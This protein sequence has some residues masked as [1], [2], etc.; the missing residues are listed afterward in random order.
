MDEPTTQLSA[1]ESF[2][3]WRVE[4][5]LAHG[6]MG[7]LYLARHP[8]LPRT[9]VIKVLSPQLSAD[10]RFRD[11]FLAE[12]TRMSTL[13]H[14]HVM[15]IYDSGT[16][17]DGT[18]YLVM[19][20]VAGGD[21]RQL[22]RSTGPL[23]PRRASRLLSQI[24]AALDAAHR[25]GVVHRDVKPE[26][27]LLSSVEP[28]DNDHALLTDFGISREE[29]SPT[30]LTATGELLLTPA[31]AAPEQAL[32]KTVDSRADQYALACILVELLT[33]RPPY[34]NDAPVVMLMA[35]LQEP[36]PALA[37]ELGLPAQ[38]DDV[39][40]RAMAKNPDE[41]YG[42]CRDFAHAVRAVLDPAGA[43]A[44]GD[45]AKPTVPSAPAPVPVQGPPPAATTPIPASPGQFGPAATAPGPPAPLPPFPGPPA[46]QR[47][48]RRTGLIVAAVVVLAGA[49]AGVAVAL[50]GGS[51]KAGAAP[52]P[53][54]SDAGP[55]SSAVPA[56]DPA[57]TALLARIPPAVAANCTDTSSTLS[58]AE[59]V[60]VP[61]RASC[62]A[63]IAGAALQVAYRPIEG[64]ANA[65]MGFRISVLKLGGNNHHGGD[66]LTLQLNPGQ[67]ESAVGF[68]Q[69]LDVGNLHGRIFCSKDPADGTLW[70]LQAGAPA[71]MAR[72]MTEMRTSLPGGTGTAQARLDELQAVAPLQ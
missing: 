4:R 69:D 31:Y 44:T 49:V 71:G 21:L 36:A 51:K 38:L 3:G 43:R 32:G 67:A 15:P 63:S 34:E 48:R 66:C 12:A 24:A 8:R 41:R 42:S 64:D 28:E 50:S 14:P 37:A 1:G 7:V 16:T 23:D 52:S 68:A 55:S 53:G 10:Q 57:Y 27:V 59:K 56:D 6:G 18:L 54:T 70:Y 39:L 35:H 5:E 20:Y 19:P 62:T 46:R 60:R 26:N 22:I 9:D 61:V 65:V 72:I 2:A 33:G 45:N 25:I 58:A 40:A 11:R 30:T 47:G 13:S 29:L 17:A